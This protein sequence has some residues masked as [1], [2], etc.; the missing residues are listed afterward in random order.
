MVQTLL[1]SFCFLIA[2]TG[3]WGA[4]SYIDQLKSELRE[5]DAEKEPAPKG[6]YSEILRRKIEDENP[7]SKSTESYVEKLKEDI[8][9]AD[10]AEGVEEEEPSKP[11]DPFIVQESQRIQ[12]R[13]QAREAEDE[14]DP[15]QPE[16]DSL[17]QA[18]KDGRSELELKRRGTV[19][20]AVGFRIAT[21]QTREVSMVEGTG[22]E[23]STLYGN[24]WAPDIQIFY[25]FHPFHSETF[26]NLSLVVGPGI[27]YHVA[28]GKFNFTLTNEK[29]GGSFGEESQTRF[30]FTTVNVY[31]GLH[32]KFNLFR[33]LRPYVGIGHDLVGYLESRSDDQDGNRGFSQSARFTGGMAFLLDWLSRKSSWDL[34]DDFSMK[35]YYLTVDYALLTPLAGNVRFKN[36]AF[37]V[38]LMFEL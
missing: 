24:S 38:G 26:G 9:I 8:R 32:Y 4:D 12:K 2:S 10:E 13:D 35:H 19:Q 1:L 34:Y 5:R 15:Y 28:D 11:G 18:T 33:F 29:T 14:G 21:A 23:F 17:I 7:Q 25:E 27:T 30:H 3:A 22:Q 20:H 37:Y 16:K 6:S 36:S 31:T